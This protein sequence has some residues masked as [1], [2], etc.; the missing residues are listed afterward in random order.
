MKFGWPAVTIGSVATPIERAE[1]PVPGKAYRQ[2]GVRWWGEGV[3]ERETIDGGNTQY[4]VMNRLEADDIVI[5][6]IWA[7][8]G[9]V[10]VVQPELAGRY[11]STEFPIFRP[12]SE[13]LEPRWFFWMTKTKWF[14]DLCDA[15]SR[16]TSGKNRI[17]PDQF[18]QIEIPLPPLAEQRRIV[19]KIARL[20][21]KIEEARGL[22][23]TSVDDQNQLLRSLLFGGS[24]GSCVETPMYELVRLRQPDVNVVGQ[25]TYHFAGIYCFGRGMFRGQIIQGTETSYKR[26]TR[27]QRGNFTYPKLMAW[28]G[29]FALVPSDCEGLVVSPEFP[30]FEVNTNRVM[31]EVLE[32]HF[33][34]PTVWAKVSGES[35]GTNVRRRRLHPNDLLRYRFPLPTSE[36][37]EAYQRVK[38]RIAAA[39]AIQ[40]QAAAELDALLPAILDRAF[41][42]AL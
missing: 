21:G 34:D 28:E 16:G 18:L 15:K 14:W 22:R 37:Q 39:S 40:A 20:A 17:R 36:T 33:T 12:D 5:N 11:C 30:V 38:T 4:A 9:S 29:A 25:D 10:S 1:T 27:L 42:G 23:E 26:L 35:T 6:K 31:P 7:R 8:H 41:K 2:I 24:G 3:Y 32:A 13:Q 19:A